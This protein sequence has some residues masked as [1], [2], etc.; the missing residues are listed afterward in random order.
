MRY[1]A[2]SDADPKLAALIDAA[3]QEPV[4]INRDQQEVAV[5][6]SAR[7]YDRLSGKAAR[8]FNDFC[9]AIADRAAARGLTEEKLEELLK[10]A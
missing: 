1:P 3:Q 4:F 7:D 9:D 2:S 10:H 5:L 8:E 6:V